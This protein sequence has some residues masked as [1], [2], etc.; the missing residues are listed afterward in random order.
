MK[1]KLPEERYQSGERISLTFR[2]IGTF[3]SGDEKKI[4]GQ[5]ATGKKREE[6]GEVF[7]GGQ[8]GLDLIWAFGRENWECEFDW[9]RWYLRERL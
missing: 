2:H 1:L 7:T 5:G 3:L 4:W 6:A 9:D 8:Q